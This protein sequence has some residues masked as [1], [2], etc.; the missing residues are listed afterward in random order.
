MKKVLVAVIDMFTGEV[1]NVVAEMDQQG[2]ITLH[3]AY[4]VLTITE[5]ED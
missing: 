2:G 3:G 4:D 5:I 1:K